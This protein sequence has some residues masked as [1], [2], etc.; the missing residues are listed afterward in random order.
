MSNDSISRVYQFL[1]KQGNWVSEADTNGDGAIIKTEFRNFMEENFEWDGTP[2]DSEKNDLINTFWNTIDTDQGGK[3]SG[4]NLRNKN[5]LD[6]KEIDSMSNRIEMYEILN[7][8]TSSITAPNVVSDVTGWKKSVSE[9]LG[10]IVEQYIKDGGKAETLEAYLTEKSPAIERKTTADYCANEYL[11]NE[12]SDFIKEYEYS[13]ADDNS[14]QNIIDTY[15]QNI[16]ADVS[17]DS[18]KE[19]IVN[20]IDA[21]L[22]TAELKDDN[23][24]DLSEFGYVINDNSMLN[25]LQKSIIKKKLESALEEIKN[26]DDY[27]LN[28]TLFDT[29][30]DDYITD[31]L[32]NSRAGDFT[33]V[34][35]YGID[36]FEA[37]DYFKT[38]EKAITLNNILTSN[39]FSSKIAEEIG[40]SFA[41]RLSNIMPG[42]IEAYDK[43]VNDAINKIKNGDFDNINKDLDENKLIEWLINELKTN[44]SD[45]Y[46]NGFGNMSIE[47][48]NMTYDSLE[49][50][51]KE[52]KD[53]EK[54]KDAAIDYCNALANKSTLLSNLVKEIFG[55]NYAT[56]INSLLSG[57]IEEKM[58]ELKDKAMEL[59]DVS[60]FTLGS[61]NCGISN[62]SIVLETGE[63]SSHVF[64]A[65]VLNGTEAIDYS[66]ITYKTT[67]STNGIT[68]TVDSGTN[69]LT[70]KGATAGTYTIDVQVLADG[71][72]I[73]N[74]QKITVTVKPS[75]A[76][77]VNNI[78]GWNNGV[79]EHLESWGYNN[80][81]QVTS[82]DFKELYNQDSKIILHVSMDTRGNGWD[83]KKTLVSDR[84]N[85]LGDLIVGALS[86]SGLDKT[87]LQAAKDIVVKRYVDA[88]AIKNKNDDGTKSKDLKN[89]C[90]DYMN[91]NRVSTQSRITW[92]VDTDGKDS[93]VYM[94]HFK[95][96]V[97]DILEEYWKLVE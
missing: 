89:N 76:D 60:S 63:S 15:I 14:L 25:D 95:D 79:S 8:F 75:N 22:A 34:Q 28:K 71:Q 59:G 12:M 18:I 27:D 40:S 16:P 5:A 83:D 36:E 77:T 91:K 33:E 41:E 24:F 50:A 61:F 85:Q 86:T 68:C 45:F 51:A 70:I 64:S 13:Y 44:I 39:D 90:L 6:S 35:S 46:P 62:N 31:I 53:S 84:L 72:K 9:G 65:T 88:G 21:Y 52:Q 55:S 20:I 4:T 26:R 23:G 1:A 37:S 74:S 29:A 48:L 92:T 47:E 82:S 49:K 7:E 38:V 94:I 96:L 17:F 67:C 10:A 56:Q 11:K 81:K 58:D 32:S 19:T 97:N 3:I 73:G 69:T 30:I 93:N 87:K 2:S 80:D 54:I 42:E 78:S 57:E 66:R 43:L